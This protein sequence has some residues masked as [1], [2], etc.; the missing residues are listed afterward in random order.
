MVSFP[1]ASPFVGRHDELAQIAALLADPACRLLTLVG[2]GG[3]GKTR[4]ALEAAQQ[5][6]DA[7]FVPLQPLTS[8]DFIV[9]AIADAVG[10]QFYSSDDP[11]RQLLDYLREKSLL[12]V[13]DNFEHLLDG[14]ILLSDMLTGALGASAAG[15]LARAPQSD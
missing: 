5:L 10:F 11:K 8:A 7:H 15:H 1:S 3:I 12:L 14:A 9:S 6:S 4:L 13:L 2:P